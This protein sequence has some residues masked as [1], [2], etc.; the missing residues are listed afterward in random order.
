MAAARRLLELP[1][2]FDAK[3][4]SGTASTTRSSSAAGV[5]GKQTLSSALPPAPAATATATAAPASAPASAVP[6]EVLARVGAEFLHADDT[7]AQRRYRITAGGGFLLIAS[8]DGTPTGKLEFRCDNQYRAAWSVLAAY[9]VNHQAAIP[10]TVAPPAPAA[11]AAGAPASPS[12]APDPWSVEG[13]THA[14]GSGLA[15]VGDAVTGAISSGLA[16]LGGGA[17]AVE[18]AIASFF[19]AAPALPSPGGATPAP[20]EA[21]P[22]APGAAPDPGSGAPAAAEGVPAMSQ[23]TWYDTT[24]KPLG[25]DDMFPAAQV[26]ASNFGFG[27]PVAKVTQP[28]AEVKKKNPNQGYWWFDA[29]GAPA[30]NGTAGTQYV[31]FTIHDGETS[32]KLNPVSAYL[33]EKPPGQRPATMVFGGKTI[34]V[35]ADVQRLDL[36]N[37]PGPRSCF[38]T[39]EAMMAQAGVHATGN[40][41]T[42]GILPITGERY[43]DYTADEIAKYPD[44]AERKAHIAREVVGVTCD[45]AAAAKAK[46]YLDFELDHGRPVFAGITYKE[47]PTLNSDQRTDHW[48]VIAARAG[49]GVYTFNDPSDGSSGKQFVWD[50]QKLYQPETNPKHPEYLYVV[51]WIRPNV[52]SLDAWNAYWAQH[53][54]AGAGDAAPPKTG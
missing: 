28:A 22:G 29:A 46:A 36:R 17:Q 35:P 42:Q 38:A 48:V 23:F 19:G 49:A 16:M 41:M 34:D 26:I 52:E 12:P 37:I 54:Q 27:G 20:G 14:I 50:G 45:P 25:V 8:S 33:A 43:R 40:D 47:A 3:A 2:M 24:F 10:A 6:P 51:S 32:S 44:E 7:T 31:T 11:P 21:A 53:Q 15:A 1:A 30:W 39:S 5:P 9:V 18:D 13:V 4:S